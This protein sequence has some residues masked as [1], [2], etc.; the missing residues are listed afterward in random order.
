[1]EN[2]N[3]TNESQAKIIQLRNSINTDLQAAK[4]F[5]E[6]E[7]PR[8]KYPLTDLGNVERFLQLFPDDVCF[9]PEE[10]DFF[11]YDVKRWVRDL[12]AKRTHELVDETVRSIY[13]EARNETDEAMRKELARFAIRSEHKNR[14][15]A[16]VNDLKHRA[17]KSIN[18]FD[19]D[20][21]L[22]NV[23]NGTIDLKTGE[24]KPHNRNDLLLKI[25]PA[26]YD[27][28][29]RCPL[30]MNTLDLFFRSDAAMIEYVQK[31]FGYTLCGVK[32]E[33]L[34][35][36]LYG[37][38]RNGKTTITGTPLKIFGDY[39]RAS[40]V[41]TFTVSK[42][43]RQ[44]GAATEDVARLRGARYVRTTEI[45]ASD[46]LNEKFVKDISGGDIITARN[47]YGRSFDFSPNFTLW[48]FGNE[49][50]RVDGQDTGIKDR[51]K[52]IPLT[53]EI[54]RDQED[55]SMR[56]RLYDEEASGILKWMVDGCLK[57]QAD[58]LREPAEVVSATDDFFAEQDPVG[59]FLRDCCQCA[60]GNSIRY[61]D[62][63]EAFSNY[64]DSQMSKFR[65]SKTLK[66]K[67]F[68]IEALS[69][70]QKY[71]M[72]LSL[73]P[74]GTKTGHDDELNLYD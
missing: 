20:Q 25:S 55:R 52:F 30:W 16:I 4:D 51:V 57:W 9:I 72:G 69:A 50:I 1:M 58:G 40:D 70:N 32:N 17:V 64:S 67:G 49:K 3:P 8:E 42:Y 62:L 37:K 60:E 33:R 15:D 44:A 10:N 14:R 13:Q 28:A 18:D 68:E 21:W 54:P 31:L 27:P 65:F 12:Q 26:I 38:G 7:N 66:D 46:K 5:I 45:G 39:G 6:R 2:N 19:R 73:R 74:D 43:G 34:I 23:Q 22:F 35:V 71:V 41:S 47:P 29:A 63:Y 59:L 36:F 53:Y 48:M 61:G 24:L 56:D 11:I